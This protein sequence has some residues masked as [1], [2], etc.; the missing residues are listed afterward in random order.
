MAVPAGVE[1]QPLQSAANGGRTES[2]SLGVP[3]QRPPWPKGRGGR[4]PAKRGGKGRGATL[5]PSSNVTVPVGGREL[6]SPVGAQDGG[7]T[8]RASFGVP[9]RRQP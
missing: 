7:R 2:A 3:C 8:G 4:S 5:D 1:A 9:R 6:A